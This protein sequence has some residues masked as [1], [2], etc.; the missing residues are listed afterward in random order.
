MEHLWSTTVTNYKHKHLSSLYKNKHL[1]VKTIM[2]SV[3]KK[4]EK[5]TTMVSKSQF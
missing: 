3:P 4:K 1:L 2:V 5:K